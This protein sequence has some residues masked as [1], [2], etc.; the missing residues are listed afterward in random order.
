MH[1]SISAHKPKQNGLQVLRILA[2]GLVLVYHVNNEMTRHNS[3]FPR[4]IEGRFGVDLFF[5]LSGYVMV[6][7]SGWLEKAAHGWWVFLQRRIVR[8]VPLYWLGTLVILAI[9]LGLTAKGRGPGHLASHALQSYLFVPY[10]DSS[11]R[12]YPILSAGWTLNFEMFFYLLFAG[13]LLLRANVIWLVGAVLSC[14]AALGMYRFTH[15]RTPGFYLDPIVL[16]FL[17]GMLLARLPVP[18]GSRPKAFAVVFLIAGLVLMLQQNNLPEFWRGL[19]VGPAAA[20][21]VYSMLPINPWFE[22]LPAA[23]LFLADATYA[24]YL[25]HLPLLLVLMHPVGFGAKTTTLFAAGL[26]SIAVCI[27]FGAAVHQ[28]VEKPI[29]AFLRAHWRVEGKQTIQVMP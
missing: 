21:M 16:E 12:Y 27:A 8:I 17:Y 1:H 6:Y 13:A 14:L 23:L 10:M 29:L 4:W 28:W 5:V 9:Q 24:I 15:H 11:G 3:A 18:Q 22:R 7:S 26:V 2:A 20:L 25:F 19:C